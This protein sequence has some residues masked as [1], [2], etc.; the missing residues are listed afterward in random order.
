M[1]L[2]HPTEEMSKTI[3]QELNENVETRDKDLQT[4][5][6]WLSKQPHLPELNGNYKDLIYHNF[7]LLILLIILINNY[8]LNC[9]II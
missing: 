1:L 8:Y 7:L 3:R 5:K 4:I 6:E 9:I 2:I